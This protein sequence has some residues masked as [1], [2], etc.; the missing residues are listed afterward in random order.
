MENTENKRVRYAKSTHIG[1]I[2]SVVSKMI[3]ES[4][5]SLH[6]AAQLMQNSYALSCIPGNAEGCAM[7]MEQTR[8]ALYSADSELAD[9]AELLSSYLQILAQRRSSEVA[10]RADEQVAPPLP[11]APPAEP[12]EELEDDEEQHSPMMEDL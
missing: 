8:A 10:P 12:P 1:D 4:M 9:A 3:C 11:S 2:P 5:V 7:A 6:K